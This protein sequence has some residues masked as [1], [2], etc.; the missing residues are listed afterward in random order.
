MRGNPYIGTEISDEVMIQ[1]LQDL[2]T[3]LGQ[4][5]YERLTSNQRARD[6]EKFHMTL[7]SPREM[8]ADFEWMLDQV[9][10][11]D[12]I[13]LGGA[14]IGRDKAYFVVAECPTGDVMRQKL[15]LGKKDFH[16]TLGFEKN[17]VHDV[18]KDRSSLML[19]DKQR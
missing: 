5:T 8:P 15:K 16:V 11:V 10:E 1:F 2:R 6:R 3:L 14:Q 7:V 19:P 13:G 4:Q 17:D 9:I 18:K 12:L